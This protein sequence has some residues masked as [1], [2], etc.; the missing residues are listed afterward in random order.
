MITIDDPETERLGRELAACSGESVEAIVR[1]AV[2]ARA[3]APPRATPEQHA[4]PE[5]QARRASVITRIQQEIAALPVLDSRS[6]DETLGYDANG[7][8]T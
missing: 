2:R 8:P 4:A 5:E 1:A 7:L 3:V 6:A